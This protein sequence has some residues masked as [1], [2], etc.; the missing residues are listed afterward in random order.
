M[1]Y[2]ACNTVP[3]CMYRP[4]I[5]LHPASKPLKFPC[6]Y[7]PITISLPTNFHCLSSPLICQSFA[8]FL[9]LQQ[10]NN[11]V[12]FKEHVITVQV[13]SKPYFD[14]EPTDKNGAEEDT[15]EIVCKAKGNPEPEVRFYRNGIPIEDANLDM[16]R[17]DSG[18]GLKWNGRV[19]GGSPLYN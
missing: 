11:G 17:S 13:Q 4:L 10:A 2:Q 14:I 16:S 5:R 8:L 19:W 12:G 15:E 3:A 18:V 1:F 7:L 6:P 9:P